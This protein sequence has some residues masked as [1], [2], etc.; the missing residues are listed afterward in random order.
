VPKQGRWLCWSFAAVITAL[1]VSPVHAD[2]VSGTAILQDL[3][4]FREMGTVLYVAAHPD[5]ENTQLITYFARGRG[6]RTAYLSVT[7]G[8]GGQNVLGPEFGEQLGVLRTQELL[9]ARRLDGGRQFFTRAID[10]GFSKNPEET[11]RIW[12]RQI[13]LSDIV[14]I[15]RSFRPDVVI[16]RF[17]P[18]GGGHGHH[19]S[20][21][22]LAVEAFKLAG[23]PN[24]FP[25][26]L[27]DLAPWQPK[28][29]LLNG[30]GDAAGGGVLRLDISGEDPVLRE[31]FSDIAGRSRSMHKTQGF[32]NFTGFGGRGGGREESF[33]L[34]A[35]A[36]ATNDVMDGIDT[37]WT[38]VLGGDAIGKLTSEIIASFNTNDP[39]GSVSS[40]LKLR[41]E[42]ASLPH[43]P[44]LDDKRTQLDRILQHCLGLSVE[45]TLPDALVVPGETMHLRH[46]AT[47]HS[48]V[49]VRW[50]ATRFPSIGQE[51]SA[52]LELK[53]NQPSERKTEPALPRDTPLSQPYWLREEHPTGTYR[54]DSPA[55]IGR[56]E[57]PPVFPVEQVF[58]I[59]GQRLV[60]KGEPVAP[61]AQNEDPANRQRLKAIPPVSLRFSS[62]VALFAPG[63][64]HPV[65]LEAT[66]A[67]A[68]IDGALRIQVPAGWRVEPASQPLQ[69]PQAGGH[70][71][72]SFNVSAPAE[73]ASATLTAHAMVQGKDFSSDRIELNF[74]HIPPQ[75]LQPLASVKAVSLQ[76]A[77]RGRQV[78]YSPGAGDSV[79]EC[80][81]QMGYQVTTLTGPDLTPERLHG[82]D[83]VV[84]GV[85]AFNVL[86]NLAPHMQAL[87]A[88]VESG[89]TLI[90]QYNRPN[91]LKV[92]QLT[93]F[94]LRISGDRVTDENAP[95]ALL[96]TNHPALTVP[97]KIT[98]ADF[99][100]WIQERGLYFPNQWDEH[101]TPLLAC[102]DPGEKPLRGGLLV[103]RHG[104]G[105]VVYSGLAWF[106]QLPGGVPGAYRL[107]ANLVSL[108]KSSDSAGAGASK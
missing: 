70:S 54:V 29:I 17:S 9:A 93:P 11:L 16:T 46:V 78:G 60:L 63:G 13:V 107:F 86:T 67:R 73:P 106:R 40:L 30:R 89:G 39:S 23:D 95:V 62:E 21:A 84:V 64:S 59:Q 97:N 41:S 8:D 14:R 56:P 65:E 3:R 18:Q 24:A 50:V 57:N 83:A 6:Y 52:T 108:G 61:S 76:M 92:D 101:F 28:R 44:L 51:Q 36:P 34:L 49:P 7:R 91:D 32:G 99:S 82:L 12:D 81:Q 90:E 69:I 27:K 4:S 74:R 2:P 85:R 72:L 47:L 104:E 31:S 58:E 80:L 37:S 100:G 55:L 42:A 48:T 79:A 87:F 102:G 43:D 10:F 98:D 22:I 35:G 15:I 68:G 53:P 105:Y 66:A 19:T 5:D 103:A 20:S 77:I 96:A 94:S 38:R 33:Q 1:A 88:Y 26:Q 25:D 75:L 45:T 71:R